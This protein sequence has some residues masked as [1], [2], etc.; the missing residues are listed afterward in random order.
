M[1]RQQLPRCHARR[2]ASFAS[3][4]GTVS[5][6]V[7]AACE[8]PETPLRRDIASV[9][10]VNTQGEDNRPQGGRVPGVMAQPTGMSLDHSH[11]LVAGGSSGIGLAIARAVL[12]RGASVTLVGRSRERL[13]A[14]HGLLGGSPDVQ[15]RSGDLTVEADVERIFAE[16]AAVDHVV[17]TAA[18]VRYGSVRDL[19]E[20]TIR[21]VIDSKLIAALFVAKHA[22]L[23]PDGS[24]LLTSGIAS[25]RPMKGGALITAANGALNALVRVLALELAP[26]R[27]NALSPGWI[28]TPI[29][30]QSLGAEK[31]QRFAD[32]A[33]RLPVGRVGKPADVAHAAV[34]LLENGYTTGEVLRI[35][36]GHLLV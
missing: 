16:T 29:W 2:R 7:T 25:E 5:D 8:Q 3:A 33:R 6:V 32:A 23:P 18:D 19:G 21:K 24:L 30:D 11:V 31:S 36:G 9:L 12:D 10:Q 28:D 13:E 4:S 35:D 26:I 20:A 1:G 34:F 15:L 22:S 17:V 14:A 27:V